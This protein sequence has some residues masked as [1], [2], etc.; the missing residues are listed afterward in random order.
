MVAQGIEDQDVG[1]TKSGRDD[2]DISQDLQ[3]TAGSP[4]RRLRSLRGWAFSIFFW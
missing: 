2:R 3:T 1:G 4:M